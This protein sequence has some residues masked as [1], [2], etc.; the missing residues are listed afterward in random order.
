MTTAEAATAMGITEQHVRRLIRDGSIQATRSGKSWVV[1]SLP[2]NFRRS[3]QRM[4]RPM[5]ETTV[6]AG[7][8]MKT[9]NSLVA[10][11]M[12]KW[13]E[14]LFGGESS[15]DFI[16]PTH[17]GVWQVKNVAVRTPEDRIELYQMAW[18]FVREAG[19]LEPDDGEE[20]DPRFQQR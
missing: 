19:L 16:G 7:R 15:I 13:A 6:E 8:A 11:E 3:K 9:T 10:R 18:R 5:K 1:S 14:R 12:A 17:R 4:K 20:K 2:S